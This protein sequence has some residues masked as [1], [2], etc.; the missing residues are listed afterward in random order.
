M[1]TNKK[2]E[3]MDDPEFEALI[4]LLRPVEARDPNTMMS[5]RV[6]FEAELD[7]MLINKAQYR[8]G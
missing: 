4:R 1:A 2:I 3:E 5:G 6:N 7:Y 8:F